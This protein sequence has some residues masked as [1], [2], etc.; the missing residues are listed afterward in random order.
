MKSKR[1]STRERERE[2]VFVHVVILYECCVA[3]CKLV[4]HVLMFVN[5]N[6]QCTHKM[7]LTF[8][9]DEIII[10]REIVVVHDVKCKGRDTSERERE[11]ERG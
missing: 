2:Y 4:L 7:M 6:T 9:L 3:V 11:R 10:L 8:R 1:E 5:A